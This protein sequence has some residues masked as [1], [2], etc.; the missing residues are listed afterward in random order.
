MSSTFF[1]FLTDPSRAPDP[2]CGLPLCA[3]P[4]PLKYTPSTW[5][6]QAH[7]TKRAPPSRFTRLPTH[8]HLLASTS[9]PLH[10]DR[11]GHPGPCLRHVPSVSRG[12]RMMMPFRCVW[13][14]AHERRT[15]ERAVGGHGAPRSGAHGVF[16]VEAS[17]GARD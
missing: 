2:A 6:R 12:L 17:L 16:L 1:F 11:N 7:M 13:L 8:V 4:G 14:A 9:G 3:H 5:Q 10:A 15:R